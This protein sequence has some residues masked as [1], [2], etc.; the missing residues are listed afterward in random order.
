MGHITLQQRIRGLAVG[1]QQHHAPLGSS[2]W[3]Y[4]PYNRQQ[5]QSERMAYLPA[6]NTVHTGE[7]LPLHGSSHRCI[8]DSSLSC[9]SVQLG[10]CCAGRSLIDFTDDR[11]SLSGVGCRNATSLWLSWQHGCLVLGLCLS[12]SSGQRC[13]VMPTF[14]DRAAGMQINRISRVSKL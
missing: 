1:P 2:R 8:S 12:R 11:D 6:A 3:E 10:F 7:V 14:S 4:A 9:R 5:V 13:Y